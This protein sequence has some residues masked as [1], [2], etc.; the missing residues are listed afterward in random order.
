MAE[1]FICPNIRSMYWY[2]PNHLLCWAAVGLLLFRS[3]HGMRGAGRDIDSLVQQDN[4][5]YYSSIL[6]Y[7]D[8]VAEEAGGRSNIGAIQRA[9]A[10]VNARNPVFPWSRT[11]LGLPEGR[12]QDFFERIIGTTHTGFAPMGPLMS[13]DG[14]AMMDF[15]R[16]HAPLAFFLRESGSTGHLMAIV[17]YWNRGDGDPNS[18]QI[19]VWDPEAYIDGLENGTISDHGPIPSVPENRYLFPHWREFIVPNIAGNRVYH[20]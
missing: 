6:R 11:P 12:T 8:A 1:E 3:R 14:R 2:Q 20:Y 18:P 17:G 16:A 19:I 9:V 15:I 4:T 7:T 5:N 13:E 10:A